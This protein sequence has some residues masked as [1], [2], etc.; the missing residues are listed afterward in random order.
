MPLRDRHH[1]DLPEVGTELTCVDWSASGQELVVTWDDVY[2]TSWSHFALSECTN[3]SLST[4]IDPSCSNGIGQQ[5]SCYLEFED[6]AQARWGDQFVSLEC[7]ISEYLYEINAR[8]HNTDHF[9]SF[10]SLLSELWAFN[11]TYVGDCTMIYESRLLNDQ[12]NFSGCPEVSDVCFGEYVDCPCASPCAWIPV[13]YT[14]PVETKA[15]IWP[16]VGMTML[17]SNFPLGGWVIF[18]LC[19]LRKKRK[20]KKQVSVAPR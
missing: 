11:P 8:Y 9:N 12:R 16:M 4:V 19:W 7:E 10:F 13:E 3:F 15:S 6:F 2:R 5:S 17:M 18:S 14:A 1:Y 20:A